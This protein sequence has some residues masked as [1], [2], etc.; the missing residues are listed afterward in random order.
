MRRGR[1]ACVARGGGA[2][3]GE[4][5]LFH[6][7]ILGCPAAGVFDPDQF[8][9]FWMCRSAASRLDGPEGQG[10]C[11]APNPP[12][13]TRSLTMADLAA[14]TDIQQDDP[15]TSTQ[16]A[17]GARLRSFIERVERLEEEKKT[18]AD[19][20]KEVYAEAK[21]QGFDVKTMRK[22]ISLRKKDPDDRAEEDALLE[23]YMAALGM[24]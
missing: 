19:D 6:G 22:I 21:G 4:E 8:G 10:Y 17:T 13:Q 12:E 11:P 18:I 20:I 15:E 3:A 23:T 1:V 16:T 14:D 2:V 7:Q 5:I 9:R 24:A